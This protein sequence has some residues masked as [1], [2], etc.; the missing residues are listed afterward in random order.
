MK[1]TRL[2]VRR[3]LVTGSSGFIGSNFLR[4]ITGSG[5]FQIIAP[6]HHHLEISHTD[7]LREI[8]EKFHPDVVIN[9]AAHRN[10]NTA[11]KQRGDTHGSAWKTNVIGVKNISRVCSANGSFLIHISSDMVFSGR[12]DHPG[13]YGEDNK[14][15]TNSRYLSWYGWTKAEGER[16]L[17]DKRNTA[18]IR[19]GNVTLPIYDP[20]LDYVGKIVYLFDHGNLYPLFYDQHLSLSSI[21]LLFEIIDKLLE[22]R[23]SGVFHA[24]SKNLFTP[25][26][27][28][29]YLIKKIRN[30]TSVV[31][32]ISIDTFLVDAPCRYPQ[33][34]GLTGKK[35]ERDLSIRLRDWK[36][37]VNKLPKLN[38]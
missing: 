26:E 2:S 7:G 24:T 25:Y 33:Y 20:K 17:L 22:T 13:P 37:I 28:G 14:P 32:K 21:P 29:E 5:N 1:K 36:E 3:I 35:T 30:K 15:E 23:E 16:F 38:I 12:K 9:F 4:H 10:A 11:E 19:I 18:I 6:D 8:F 27:L 31:Q 34:G